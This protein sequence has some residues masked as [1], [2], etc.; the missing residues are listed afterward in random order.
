MSPHVSTWF[1]SVEVKHLDN[2]QIS[3][4]PAWNHENIA[5]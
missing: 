2:K 4:L 5:K 3:A 1:K